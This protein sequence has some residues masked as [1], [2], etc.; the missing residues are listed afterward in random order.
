MDLMDLRRPNIIFISGEDMFRSFE[1]LKALKRRYINQA[2]GNTN[3]TEVEGKKV[4]RT[5]DILAQLSTP[6]FLAPK[7]MIVIENLIKNNLKIAS[8]LADQLDGIPAFSLA[9]FYE[10]GE[11]DA[12]SKLVKKL[13]AQAINK[14]FSALTS[15][16]LKKWI[17]QKFFQAGKKIDP[18][19]LALLIKIKI[20]EIGAIWQEIQK[21]RLLNKDIIQPED[22]RRLAAPRFQDKSYYLTDLFLSSASHRQLL[23]QLDRLRL[24]G[25]SEQLT[26]FILVG[27]MRNLLLM[28]QSSLK[29]STALAGELKINYFLAKKLANFREPGFSLLRKFYRQLLNYDW[30]IKTGK[31]KISLALDLVACEWAKIKR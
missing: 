28:S 30:A 9:V 3:L 22:V 12:R 15:E 2:L 4:I 5:G 7:R 1:Y 23:Y 27:L 19:A 16:E 31:I 10:K 20:S 26:F 14:S 21:L 25:E 24:S 18:Q 17:E 13:Q 11:P 8:Q 29:S 6:P